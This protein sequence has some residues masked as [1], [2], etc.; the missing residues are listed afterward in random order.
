MRLIKLPEKQEKIELVADSLKQLDLTGQKVLNLY[1]VETLTFREIGKILKISESRVCQTTSCLS[2][3][4]L[5]ELVDRRGKNGGI[6]GR[7]R[8]HNHRYGA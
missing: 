8:I 2:I 5:Q 6:E 3:F 7:E 1:Y 4:R